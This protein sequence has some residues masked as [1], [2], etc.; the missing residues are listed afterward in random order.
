MCKKIDKLLK[1][2]WEVEESQGQYTAMRRPKRFHWGWFVANF[3]L[4]NIFGIAGYII[5]YAAKGPWQRKI[6]RV[7]RSTK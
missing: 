4:F 6:V 1:K 3:I 5:Y 7:R 2:G